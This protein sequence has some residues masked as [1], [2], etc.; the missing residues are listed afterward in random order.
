LFSPGGLL[1]LMAGVT[2]VSSVPFEKEWF[3]VAPATS[4]FW[5]EIQEMNGYLLL[6]LA[7]CASLGK[8]RAACG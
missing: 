5:E 7:A 4:M 1:A 2:L 3:E 6:L 8:A